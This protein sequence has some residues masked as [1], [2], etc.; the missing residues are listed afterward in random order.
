MALAK[1]QPA[2]GWLYLAGKEYR[3]CFNKLIQMKD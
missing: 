3:I 2:F 1:L